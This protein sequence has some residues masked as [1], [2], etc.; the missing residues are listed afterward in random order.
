MDIFKSWAR[1]SLFFCYSWP[2]LWVMGGKISVYTGCPVTN[3]V[4][5]ICVKNQTL[6][7]IQILCLHTEKKKTI[8]E[9]RL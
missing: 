5:E 8:V 9:I 6:K 1:C 7:L 4:L 2:Y 3:G